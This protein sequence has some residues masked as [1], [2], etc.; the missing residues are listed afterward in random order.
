MLYVYYCLSIRD[1]K[2]C[3]NKYLH[4]FI[5]QQKLYAL[6]PACMDKSTGVVPCLF[7]VIVSLKSCAPFVEC[8][9]QSQI[10]IVG[11]RL[12]STLVEGF[13]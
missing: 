8:Y 12:T 5:C 3:L 9:N 1:F 2:D 6:L 11:C 10:L 4:P 7:L 13:N